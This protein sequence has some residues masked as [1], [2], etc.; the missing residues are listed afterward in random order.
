MEGVVEVLKCS[1]SH[2][3][4]EQSSAGIWQ[5][6]SFP[7]AFYS[8]RPGTRIKKKFPIKTPDRTTTPLN[9]R[10]RRQEG[11]KRRK[12]GKEGR[13]QAREGRRKEGRNPLP[14]PST[15]PRCFKTNHADR[16]RIVSS[17]CLLPQP[18]GFLKAIH[19]CNK[20]Q[21]SCHHHDCSRGRLCGSFFLLHPT[22]QMKNL[23]KCC[24]SQYLRS[25]QSS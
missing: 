1:Y 19:A 12:E 5:T 14:T 18:P 24:S 17:P 22:V 6:H 20:K 10:H 9:Y 16:K 2:S 4:K 7:V 3:Q 13:M 25:S 15:P 8:W 21:A 23:S 11:E